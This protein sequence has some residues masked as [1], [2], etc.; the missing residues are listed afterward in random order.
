M[1][2]LTKLASDLN[3]VNRCQYISDL[4]AHAQYVDS[5]H[6]RFY[7]DHR[8]RQPTQQLMREW[9]DDFVRMTKTFN[10]HIPDR[11]P[12]RIDPEDKYGRCYPPWDIRW[13]ITARDVTGNTHELVHLMLFKYSDV[14]FF[15]EPLAFIYG[16]YK[17]NMDTV[18]Q[19]WLEY[20]SMIADSGYISATELLHFP[21][22]IGLDRLK[23]A[24]TGAA[25]V[26]ATSR[27]PTRPARVL[28]REKPSGAALE[29]QCPPWW[30]LVPD[31][32]VTCTLT[33]MPER[34][35]AVAT[36]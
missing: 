12:Y 22:I 29:P 7:Y 1:A 15:H 13:G 20:E 35:L 8:D 23:R 2:L 30:R 25:P 26:G 33:G 18:N 4:E 21:Q 6:F 3:Y 14:P 24:T 27:W 36:Q 32:L 10:S 31:A 5:D 16:T 34:M 9:D 11:I 19:H 17:A 28:A